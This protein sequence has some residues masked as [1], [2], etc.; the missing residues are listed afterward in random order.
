MNV[1]VQEEAKSQLGLFEAP[2]YIY[3]LKCYKHKMK[4]A[5]DRQ[6][7]KEK[8]EKK[9][10]L[11]THPLQSHLGSTC[12]EPTRDPPEVNR[13]GEKERE[14]ELREEWETDLT[15]RM[16]ARQREI[17]VCVCV[18]VS[19]VNPQEVINALSLSLSLSLSLCVWLSFL[20]S[21]LWRVWQGFI[22]NQISHIHYLQ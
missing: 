10:C 17:V 11:I 5:Q 19:P 21:V 15:P 20:P 3:Y 14:R 6:Q 2:T 7:K 4:N 18:C 1:T 12:P 13:D 8:K 16:R 22:V 9:E